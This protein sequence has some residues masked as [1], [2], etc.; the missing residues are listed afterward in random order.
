[1]GA[2]VPDLFQVEHQ[3][4][5]FRTDQNKDGCHLSTSYRVSAAI[6]FSS[7][8]EFAAVIGGAGSRSHPPNHEHSSAV[9]HL[10]PSFFVFIASN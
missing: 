1:M 3:V 9:N 6:L 5:T 2:P 8:L 7:C 10:D 4:P